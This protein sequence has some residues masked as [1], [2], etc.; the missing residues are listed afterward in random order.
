MLTHCHFF[1]R[2]LIPFS[3]T[4]GVPWIKVT[5]FF[6]PQLRLAVYLLS[7]LSFIIERSC[8]NVQGWQI[9]FSNSS[10]TVLE[11]RALV[12]DNFITSLQPQLQPQ[13]QGSKRETEKRSFFKDL[14]FSDSVPFR[15]ILI[16]VFC[17]LWW[18]VSSGPSDHQPFGNITSLVEVY[19]VSSQCRN[20]KW[21]WKYRSQKQSDFWQYKGKNKWDFIMAGVEIKDPVGDQS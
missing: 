6:F 17:L 7:I 13:H 18:D 15:L 11:G 3:L 19:E 10:I 5:S 14:K 12:R 20:F 16:F 1:T 21:K 4:V 2:F 9:E 8:P